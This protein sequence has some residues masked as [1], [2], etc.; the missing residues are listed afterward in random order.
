MYHDDFI[1]CDQ[2]SVFNKY[3]DRL[4]AR[5]SLHLIYQNYY[6]R[7][8]WYKTILDQVFHIVLVVGVC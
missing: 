5:L 4:G 7:L 8:I 6:V 2:T 3:F 1:S